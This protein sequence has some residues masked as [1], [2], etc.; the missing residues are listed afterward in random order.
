MHGWV[1]VLPLVN[2]ILLNAIA[3]FSIAQGWP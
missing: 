3:R 2:L 1:P